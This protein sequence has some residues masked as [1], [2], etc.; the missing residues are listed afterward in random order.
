MFQPTNQKT[1]KKHGIAF[2]GFS[3]ICCVA[4]LK[5]RGQKH[6][7]AE[8]APR[9]IATRGAQAQSGY[10]AIPGTFKVVHLEENVATA[11]SSYQ[12]RTLIPWIDKDGWNTY[13]TKGA[14]QRY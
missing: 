14:S 7:S 10:A 8:A 12:M 13:R 1:K 3:K 5:N 9:N 6:A 2:K 11:I 4:P